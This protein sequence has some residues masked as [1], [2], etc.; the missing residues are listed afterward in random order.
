V[1]ESQ[2][3]RIEPA[4][5]AE[6]MGVSMA[7]VY[8]WIA[9]D[10]IPHAHVGEQRV[11]VHRAQFERWFANG[12]DD[13]DLEDRIARAVEKALRNV[14]GDFEPVVRFQQRTP[15]P[16]PARLTALRG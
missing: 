16:N 12:P 11:V 2:S 7:T 8:A 6:R 14:L 10:Y 5:I 4:E 13:G 3:W 9:A 1:S 15:E